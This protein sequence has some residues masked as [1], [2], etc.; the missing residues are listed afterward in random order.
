MRLLDIVHRPV[1]QEKTHAGLDPDARPMGRT[2]STQIPGRE[3]VQSMAGAYTIDGLRDRAEGH[4][5][6]RRPVRWP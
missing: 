5:P 6:L 3:G 1:L 4:L 2:G